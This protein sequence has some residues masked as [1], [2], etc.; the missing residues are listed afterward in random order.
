MKINASLSVLLHIF[1]PRAWLVVGLVS[2]M[3]AVGS[4]VTLA[5]HGNHGLNTLLARTYDTVERFLRDTIR[6]SF[7]NRR[8]GGVQDA[9]FVAP[10]DILE[11]KMTFNWIDDAKDFEQKPSDASPEPIAPARIL[12]PEWRPSFSDSPQDKKSR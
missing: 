7:K 8:V 3:L 9:V 10:R 4:G 6:L 11:K 2:S 12:D 1:S 5:L